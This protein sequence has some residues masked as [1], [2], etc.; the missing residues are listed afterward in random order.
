MS[1]IDDFFRSWLD[2]MIDPR[3][4]LAVLATHIPWQE[5][6]A[7]VAHRFA[8]QICTGKRV[9]DINLFDP[10]V[11]VVGSGNSNRARQWRPSSTT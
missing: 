6:E 5:L 11:A 7:A 2:Q 9:E 10:T 8:R 1:Q 3:K 4:P